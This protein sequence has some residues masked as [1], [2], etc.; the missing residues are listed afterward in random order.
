MSVDQPF[1]TGYLDWE[2][3]SSP[4][5]DPPAEALA[6]AEHAVGHRVTGW[7]PL[8]GGMSSAVHRLRLDGSADPVVLR[9]YTLADWMEREPNIPYDEARILGVLGRLELGVATPRL[10]AADPDG[11]HCDVPATLMT[12]V[13]G[14]PDIDPAD[15]SRWAHDLATCLAGIHAA[16]I[17]DGLST[18]GRWDRPGSPIPSWATDRDLWRRAKHEVSGPLPEHE[19]VFLHRDFH[20]SNVHWRRGS[21]TAVVDWLSAC[22]GSAAVDVAHCRW[23]LAV[24]VGVEVAEVFTE[25]YRSLTGYRES[26]TAHDLSTILSGPVGPFPTFA[27]NDLGRNDLTSESV[28]VKIETWLAHV[29]AHM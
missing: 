2:P 22:V 23:N 4:S 29:L 5:T 8:P 10:L 25:T 9:R 15:P 14:R 28:A 1:E 13:A 17:P 11:R 21:I 27:W 20:P 3:S 19:P 16:P 7:D 24:L 12:E 6:W 26:V 18:F